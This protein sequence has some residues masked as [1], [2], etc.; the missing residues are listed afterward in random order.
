MAKIP[1]THYVN[2][3]R[4]DGFV[5]AFTVGKCETCHGEIEE[6][7]A[8]GI[9]LR[10]ALGHGLKNLRRRLPEIGHNE[11]TE[12]SDCEDCRGRDL[13]EHGHDLDCHHPCI[14]CAVDRADGLGDMQREGLL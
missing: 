6:P 11:E 9:E 4:A 8:V 3:N 5:H 7:N 14:E 13:C 10:T 12:I 1:W 2:E